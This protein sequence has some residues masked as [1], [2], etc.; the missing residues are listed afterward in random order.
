M[1]SFTYQGKNSAVLIRSAEPED[2]PH[3]I[4]LN[5]KAFPSMAEENVVW[6]ERQLRN[7]LKVFPDGQLVAVVD[8]K[9]VGAAASLIIPNSRDPY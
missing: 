4:E 9:V 5:T 8:G 3:L 6:S 2:I 7:H 1:E